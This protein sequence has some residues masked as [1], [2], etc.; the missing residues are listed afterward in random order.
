MV[1]IKR[2]QIVE[3]KGRKGSKDFC[4]SPIVT[5]TKSELDEWDE[6]LIYHPE[7]FNPNRSEVKRYN[8]SPNDLVIWVQKE[9]LI[10]K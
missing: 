6:I 3:F 7:G 9:E 8:L 1:E 2:E 10:I 5:N 4:I